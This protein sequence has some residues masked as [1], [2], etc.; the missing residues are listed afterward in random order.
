M[1]FDS[2]EQT[3]IAGSSGGTLKLWDLEH[4]KVARTLT[5]HRCN[6][7]S[8]QAAPAARPPRRAAPV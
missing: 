7:G 3:V 2:S 4:G 5:G 1:S 6:C 8:V